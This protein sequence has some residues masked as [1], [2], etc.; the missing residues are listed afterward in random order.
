MSSGDKNVE[1]IVSSEPQ[2]LLEE[3]IEAQVVL[4]AESIDSDILPPK[5]IILVMAGLSICVVLAFLDQTIVG[6]AL[7]SISASLPGTLDPSWV[8]TSYLL[9]S[10][11]FGPLYGRFADIFGRKSVLIFSLLIFL[12]GSLGCGVAQDMIQLVA[13]RAVAG[14]GGA[15]MM[16]LVLISISDVVSLRER[17]K[18][19]GVM[20]IVNA[21]GNA[22]GPPLGGIF[23][24]ELS[25]RWGFLIN[26]PLGAIGIIIVILFLPLKKIEGNVK[27]KLK[28]ID[29]LGSFLVL[30]GNM[31]L[32]LPIIW[33]GD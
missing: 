26:L 20:G 17:G 4:D 2:P 1:F 16:T 3:R 25:W 15:G 31:L 5:K 21:L 33:F 11:C 7:P 22:L 6:T 27:E 19:Q 29:Y 13:M 8:G 10:A 30:S 9:T 14:A 12:V 32:L 23:S 28:K 24:E 18:Y